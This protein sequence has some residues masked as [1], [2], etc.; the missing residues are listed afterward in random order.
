M[1]HAPDASVLLAAMT[2]IEFEHAL[3]EARR[4]FPFVTV[5]SEASFWAYLDSK[6][7][8]ARATS[9][10]RS[11]ARSATPRPSSSFAVKSSSE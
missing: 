8:T 6:S 10:S 11:P 7:S 1:A 9:T 4:A 2:R 3:D 5:V